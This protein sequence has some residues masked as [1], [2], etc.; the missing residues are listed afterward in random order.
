MT[1]E[2]FNRTWNREAANTPSVPLD[3]QDIVITAAFFSRQDVW[4]F[5]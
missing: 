5:A 4:R 3:V 2:N 1:T